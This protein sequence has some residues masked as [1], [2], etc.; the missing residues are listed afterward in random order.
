[1][2]NHAKGKSDTTTPP[3]LHASLRKGEK[4]EREKLQQ[5]TYTEVSLALKYSCSYMVVFLWHDSALYTL[6]VKK[7]MKKSVEC[8]ECWCIFVS[9]E[10]YSEILTH[11]TL[12][13]FASF[14]SMLSILDKTLNKTKTSLSLF[15]LLKECIP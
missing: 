11:T 13:T 2:S 1:M 4:K 7:N 12:F 3:R 15:F 8:N 5:E 6:L 14:H 9:L 10:C